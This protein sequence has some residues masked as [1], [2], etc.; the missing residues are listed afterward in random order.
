M[1]ALSRRERPAKPALTREGIIDA[2]VRVMESDGLQRVTMRRLAQE[3]D[4]GPAS[5]Y[6]YVANSYELHAAILDRLLAQ[7][8]LTA[9]K[10]AADWR[11]ALHEVLGSYTDLLFAH[12]SLA[13]SAVHTHPDGPHYLALVDSLLGLLAAGQVPAGQAAWGVDLLLQTATATA[14]EH[15]ND[16]KDGNAEAA[17]RRLNEA[18]DNA[19]AQQFPN[20]HAHGV[21]LL[22]GT[23]SERR[24]WAFDMLI[25]GIIATARP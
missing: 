5:L 9:A 20:L 22:S 3:L 17:F 19:S 7:V 16:S 13:H 2:A 6:V 8:D 24:R 15:A 11:E 23:P 1:P 4:T 12:P 10:D 14:A 25:N 18:V 21:D